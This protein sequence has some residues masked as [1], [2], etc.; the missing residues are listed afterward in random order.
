MAA[1]RDGSDVGGRCILVAEDDPVNLMLMDIV[2]RER[3]YEV[4]L[5]RDGQEVLDLLDAQHVDAVLMDCQMPVMDGFAATGHIRAGD[6]ARGRRLPIV[7]LTARAFASDRQRC[8][9]A[10]MDDYLS[11]PIQLD[12]LYAAVARWAP[13]DAEGAGTPAG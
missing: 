9:D 11:K 4:V 10:G 5:A 2:L 13:L 1:G 8:L 3:G 12:A 6:A 7:A